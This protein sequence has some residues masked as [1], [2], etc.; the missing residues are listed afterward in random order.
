M[1]RFC[2]PGWF[3]THVQPVN[4]PLLAL[5]EL[6]H[7]GL[8][9]A[10]GRRPRDRRDGRL[11]AEQCQPRGHPAGLGEDAFGQDP[12]SSRWIRW[13]LGGAPRPGGHL[14]DRVS[15]ANW[16]SGRTRSHVVV[17]MSWSPPPIL[18]IFE[19]C[20]GG[21]TLQGIR[22]NLRVSLTYLRSW[23]QGRGAVAIDNL[24]EDAAAVE[25]SRMQLWQW[26][27]HGAYT[28][29]GERVTRDLV[30]GML[31]EEVARLR[32]ETLTRLGGRSRRLAT[33]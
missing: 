24:M 8:V 13:L 11:R 12:R 23:L 21:V 26:I 1:G 9:D 17:T 31:V 22:T 2:S 3:G 10:R 27:R 15:T 6:Q 16:G 18:L 7:L 19:I 29:S 20:R 14:H 33:S 32:A 4:S 5:Q 28:T 25:I 30:A